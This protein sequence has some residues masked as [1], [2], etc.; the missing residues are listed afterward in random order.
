MQRQLSHNLSRPIME[1]VVGLVI[2]WDDEHSA[3]LATSSFAEIA[4]RPASLWI[5]VSRKSHVHPLIGAT[6]RFS[7][8]VLSRRQVDLAVQFGTELGVGGKQLDGL[9]IYR[10]EQGNVFLRRSLAT[11]ACKVRQTAEV[12]E[13]TLFLAD[14]VESEQD[15][16]LTHVKP[17][18]NTHLPQE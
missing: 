10:S 2:A 5:A 9:D 15:S 17:L 6:G 7:L 14:I 16:R 13:Y 1:G 8:A 4:H 3:A 12:D 11:T 18:L